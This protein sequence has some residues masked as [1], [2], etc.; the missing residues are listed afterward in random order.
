MIVSL[1]NALLYISYAILIGYFIISLC[2][3]S[4]KESVHI[5]K[6]WILGSIL[7][8]PLLS[9]V[10]LYSLSLQMASEF[11]MDIGEIF[12]QVLFQFQVGRAWIWTAVLSFVLFFFCINP[13]LGR[14]QVLQTFGLILSIGIIF[15]QGWGSHAG[16]LSTAN[17]LFQAMHVLTVSI[18][19]GVLF[20]VAWFSRDSIDWKKFLQQYTP[21]AIICII[22]L[23]AAGILMMQD[24]VPSYF[25]SWVLSYGQALLIKHLLFAA[26]LIFALVNG[27][28]VRKKL[29][30]NQPN[31]I[32]SWIR[33]ESILV[34]FVFFTTAFMTEQSPPHE[35]EQVLAF[36]EASWLYL[37]FSQ[38][39]VDLSQSIIPSVNLL[40]ISL[41]IL[42]VL[43]GYSIVRTYLSKGS[44]TKGFIYSLLFVF[45]AYLAVMFAI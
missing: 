36:E 5:P 40:S 13:F 12:S 26:I 2:F 17:F 10:S 39:N 20:L 24:I 11:Q 37:L 9:F 41:G 21:I 43:W 45:F 42:A 15:A 29:K 32:L 28:L 38:G 23:T 44:A 16:S 33:A 22:I 3:K 34:L 30:A 19:V 18:W 1:S 25:N 8:I 35:L 6:S 7:S 27:I 14:N 31:S 4:L